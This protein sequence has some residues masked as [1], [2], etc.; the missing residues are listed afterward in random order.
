MGKD[1]SSELAAVFGHEIS[2]WIIEQANALEKSRTK[3]C[4][5]NALN[6]LKWGCE[7]IEISP[8]VATFCA[9]NATEE[10]VAA[11]I[12]AAKRHGHPDQAK[13]I[14]LH[15]HKSKALVSIFA[16]RCSSLAKRG[17]LAIAVAPDRKSLA[18][19]IPC[20]DRYQYGPL[21]LS[22]LRL[23]SDADKSGEDTILKV[24][25][26][27][28]PEELLREIEKVAEAR[29]N[30]LYAT[31]KGVTPGFKN[32]EASLLREIKLSL[33]LIWAAVDICKNPEHHRPFV[34][35]LLQEMTV[36]SDKK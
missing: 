2:Q 5:I 7:I 24:G 1:P 15:N 14:D 19:R 30:L 11:F 10:S 4:C 18:Y 25:E 33:G 9:L 13:K 21:H 6:F 17:N 32:P 8:V 28:E 36:I 35:Q 16:A 3:Y 26:N 31:N 22:L 12:S 29:N 34:E 20:K 23:S 27:P